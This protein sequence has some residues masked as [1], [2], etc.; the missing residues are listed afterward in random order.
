MTGGAFGGVVCR[1]H[2]VCERCWFKTE[3]EYGVRRVENTDTKKHPVVTNPRGKNGFS[4]TC[5]GCA[6]K[7]PF[8]KT[9]VN[10]CCS[11]FFRDMISV[12]PMAID[13]Q[14]SDDE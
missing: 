14:D 6:Y 4:P 9:R 7:V 12:N 10:E 1:Y 5:F 13:L 2:K 11:V 8:H 3:D